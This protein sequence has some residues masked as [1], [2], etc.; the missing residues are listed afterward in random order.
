MSNSE[1]KGKKFDI[2]QWVLMAPP[3]AYIFSHFYLKLCSK[4]YEKSFKNDPHM[5]ISN[6]SKNKDIFKK[7]NKK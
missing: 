2:R 6:Y 4:D 3:K 5:H 7:S 1:F